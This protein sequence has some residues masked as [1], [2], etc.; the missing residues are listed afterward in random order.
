MRGRAWI[1]LVLLLGVGKALPV[2]PPPLI[3]AKSA[4][5]IEERTG[6]VL[7][8]KGADDRRFPASTTKIMTALLLIERC[9]PEE[10]ITAPADVEK[11]PPSSLH[12]K[13]G[14]KVSAQNMLYALMLR[15]ANDAAYAVACHIGG[16]EEGFAQLMN[17]RAK[18]IGCTHTHFHNPHGLNDDLHSTSARD[19]S[20]MAR[21]AMKYPEFRK[22][23]ATRKTQITRSINQEDLWLV[24]KNKPLLKDPTADGI[25][26]GYTK[27]AGHCYVGSAVRNGF[28]VI[29]VVLASPDWQLDHFTLLDWA[30]KNFERKQVEAAG[31]V[32]RQVPL[33]NGE[34]ATVQ[35]T[36]AE[37]VVCVV[38][39]SS[40]PDVRAEVKPEPGLAAPIS[41]GATVGTVVFSDASG[42]TFET[43]LVA[44][45]TI[46]LKRPSPLASLGLSSP[47]TI[48]VAGILTG[49]TY[50]MRRKARSM[51]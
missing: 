14:E 28:R 47:G 8:E 43:P 40:A 25:K 12:L 42:W 23:V 45:E 27:P 3:Q 9:R 24:S 6:R 51:V 20:L 35:A 1:S 13:P 41:A 2:E 18:A 44:S 31:E 17:G 32:T 37:P 7:F 5:V 46:S 30:Y 34:K 48:L 19:L 16:N 49:A 36:I 38:S 50:L 10:I 39:K 15:S 33:A 11:V 29:T 26:T 22:V 4:I 21:E